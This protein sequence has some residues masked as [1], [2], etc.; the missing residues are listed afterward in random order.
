MCGEF[1]FS[2]VSRY[3][4][5]RGSPDFL[6]TLYIKLSYGEKGKFNV[7]DELLNSDAATDLTPRTW[8]LNT[9][10]ALKLPTV[11]TLC[12]EN[13]VAPPCFAIVPTHRYWF[14][15]RF[16]RGERERTS[17]LARVSRAAV[18]T[19]EGLVTCTKNLHWHRDKKKCR[20]DPSRMVSSRN[21]TMSPPTGTIRHYT[22]NRKKRA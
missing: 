19:R 12:V 21:R 8:S 17:S 18:R 1:S 13:L 9:R 20:E 11:V 3:N 10:I 22:M 5:S 4:I 14:L 16:I 7:N 15:P 2:R 6:L